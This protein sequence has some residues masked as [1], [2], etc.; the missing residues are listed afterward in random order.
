MHAEVYRLKILIKHVNF[1]SPN[2]ESFVCL[3]FYLKLDRNVYATIQF[4]I[5]RKIKT[6]AMK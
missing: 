1:G 2:I 6:S 5:V 4:E 3:S